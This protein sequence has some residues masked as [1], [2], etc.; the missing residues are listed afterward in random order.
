MELEQ[1]DAFD[2]GDEGTCR[3]SCTWLHALVLTPTAT[4]LRAAEVSEQDSTPRDSGPAA[5]PYLFSQYSTSAS[6]DSMV[7]HEPHLR[8]A[9]ASLQMPGRSD[10]AEGTSYVA[11]CLACR[12]VCSHETALLDDLENL[13]SSRLLGPPACAGSNATRPGQRVEE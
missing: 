9:H 10:D 7:A 11:A 12:C 1:S 5:P 4:S 3:R 6:S 2:D 13:E 8:G